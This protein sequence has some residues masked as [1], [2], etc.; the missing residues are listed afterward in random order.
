VFVS[1]RFSKDNEARPVL[2]TVE[3]KGGAENT[4]GTNL[5][6]PIAFAGPSFIRLLSRRNVLFFELLACWAAVV[7]ISY[8]DSPTSFSPM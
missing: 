5:V 3:H 4:I 2:S 6:V 7:E 1:H 8:G